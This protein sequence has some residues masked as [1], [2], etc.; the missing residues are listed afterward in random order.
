MVIDAHSGHRLVIAKLPHRPSLEPQ[1]PMEASQPSMASH[2][3]YLPYELLFRIVEFQDSRETLSSLRLVSKAISEVASKHLFRTITTWIVDYQAATLDNIAKHEVLSRHVQEIVFRPWELVYSKPAFDTQAYLRKVWHGDFRIRKETMPPN[4]TIE[5]FDDHVQAVVQKKRAEIPDYD[6]VIWSGT[7]ARPMYPP[8]FLEQ[9][10]ARYHEA[11]L[12]YVKRITGGSKQKELASPLAK[13]SNLSCVRIRNGNGVHSQNCQLYRDTGIKPGL[14]KGL[15]SHHTFS[16]VMYSLA[17]AK[18]CLRSL[19]I[20][21]E[22]L[23]TI[24][25]EK[26]ISTHFLAGRNP[27]ILGVFRSVHVLHLRGLHVSRA[28]YSWSL[29]NMRAIARMVEACPELRALKVGF[30]ARSRHSL[31]LS[32]LLPQQPMRHLKHLL[33]N[34][35]VVDEDELVGVL[36]TQKGSLTRLQLVCLCLREGSWLSLVDKVHNRLCLKAAALRYLFE[37]PD[38]CPRVQWRSFKPVRTCF[39]DN[40]QNETAD[41]AQDYLCHHINFNPLRR[42]LESGSEIQPTYHFGPTYNRIVGFCCCCPSRPR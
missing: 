3:A 16:S 24:L 6:S 29:L 20:D 15:Y 19:K 30:D 21:P 23:D 39:K 9:G 18:P 41:C 26:S 37:D 2:G 28:P 40:P 5:T 14:L 1:L 32:C 11:Y 38:R 36:D 22:E 10:Q 25:D 42:A 17:K 4:V 27:K 8:S 33:L 7:Y 31:P 35:L 34:C 12:D 13:F